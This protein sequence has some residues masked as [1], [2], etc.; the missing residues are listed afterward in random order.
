MS[1]IGNASIWIDC[2][3]LLPQTYSLVNEMTNKDR[4]LIGDR[5]V[6][7]NI[8]MIKNFA[9]AYSRGDEKIINI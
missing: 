7:Y 8:D 9:L 4:L 6:E 3:Q 5:L 2:K 1:A